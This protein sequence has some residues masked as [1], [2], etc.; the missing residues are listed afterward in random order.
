[1]NQLRSITAIAFLYGILCIG[2][3]IAAFHATRRV[4]ADVLLTIPTPVTAIS[5]LQTRTVCLDYAGRMITVY[6]TFTDTNGNIRSDGTQS[7]PFP[8]PTPAL[9]ATIK[10]TVEQALAGQVAL[11]ALTPVAAGTV[12]P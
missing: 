4:N 6:Y 2:L 3:G 8:A 1:M 7:F 11:G 5:R 12:T 10:T 9:L